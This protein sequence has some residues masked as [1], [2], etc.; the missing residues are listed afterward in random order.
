MTPGSAGFGFP[1]GGMIQPNV[2]SPPRTLTL[3]PVTQGNMRVRRYSHSQLRVVV[4]AYSQVTHS[5]R[6]IQRKA[7]APRKPV[8]T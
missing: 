1:V 7:A 5:V 6:V 4:L 3:H 8:P 2:I